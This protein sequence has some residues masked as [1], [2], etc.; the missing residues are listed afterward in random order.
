MAPVYFN[1]VNVTKAY[2]NGRPVF[3]NLPTSAVPWTPANITTALWLDAAD[4]STVILNGSTVSRWD[5]KSGNGRNAV[6]DTAAAQP[7]YSTSIINGRP[8]IF[9]D[10][11]DDR[12]GF[13]SAIIPNNFHIFAV[14]QPNSNDNQKNF[15][16]NQFAGG[17]GRLQTWF[18]RPG[19]PSAAGMQVGNG[20]AIV[21]NNFVLNQTEIIEWARWNNVALVRVNGDAFGTGPATEEVQNINTSLFSRDGTFSQVT[22]GEIIL[23]NQE[24]STTDRQRLEGYL[25]WKWGLQANLP[26]DHPYKTTAPTV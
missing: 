20:L 26:A 24:L 15:L 2:L 6:Q 3:L 7:T 11:N 8:A 13:S 12:L 19:S 4:A 16:V 10:G 25:A 5:D 17:T 21:Q 14:G 9:S 23:L 1:G 18:T 22:A